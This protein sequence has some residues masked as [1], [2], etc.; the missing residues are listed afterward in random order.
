MLVAFQGFPAPPGGKKTGAVMENVFVLGYSILLLRSANN[1]GCGAAQRLPLLLSAEKKGW[2]NMFNKR[3]VIGIAILFSMIIAVFSLPAIA[4]EGYGNPQWEKIYD[5]YV[6]NSMTYHDGLY[7]GVGYDGNIGIS[8][9]GIDWEYPRSGTLRSLADITYGAA[10]FVAVG[11]RVILISDDGESWQP[12]ELGLTSTL[13]SIAY[14]GYIFIALTTDGFFMTSLDGLNWEEY[15]LED[16]ENRIQVWSIFT[17]GGNFFASD[18]SRLFISENGIDWDPIITGKESIGNGT[19]YYSNVINHKGAYMVWGRDYADNFFVVVSAD[20]KE[21][22]TKDIL[23]PEFFRQIISD[24]ERILA[25]GR[26]NIYISL[27]GFAWDEHAVN[28][29]ESTNKSICYLNGVFF[30]TI[31]GEKLFISTNGLDWT[32]IS[33]AKNTELGL[34]TA[35]GSD[36]NLVNNYNKTPEIAT[37]GRIQVK[38]GGQET[39]D[40]TTGDGAFDATMS[41]GTVSTSIDGKKWET[42]T[43]NNA[44]GLSAVTYGKG[45][46]VAVGSLGSIVTSPDGISWKK[47]AY[48]SPPGSGRP[49][50]LYDIIWDKGQYIAAGASGIIIYSTDGITWV[51]EENL[52]TGYTINQLLWDDDRYVG[53]CKEAIITAKRTRNFADIENHWAKNEIISLVEKGV[54]KG[55]SSTSFEPERAISRAEFSALLV[56]A[57]QLT[58]NGSRVGFS[59]LP[60]SNWFYQDIMILCQNEIL[61]GYEDKT[62]RPAKAISREEAMTMIARAMKLIEADIE[63]FGSTGDELLQTFADYLLIS[64]WAKESVA[65]C[66][67]ANIVKGSG[68][69]I[70][71]AKDITRAETAAIIARLLS[72]IESN[73]NNKI[74]GS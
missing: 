67:G 23:L 29:G 4:V 20:G 45:Q 39:E 70:H 26:D 56:R 1:M 3:I 74:N 13:K 47:Q 5:S 49:D 51:P 68:N 7:V 63:E 14:N 25:L 21:W 18:N 22:E 24:G 6:F 65:I 17:D 32:E 62:I 30:R 71:P 52:A 61:H 31:Y 33:G 15:Y 48:P 41:I 60:Q 35:A 42:R 37:N 34:I 11:D 53:V 16:S 27:D 64:E 43:L 55:V 2:V 72:L 50:P 73:F 59:D 44:Y 28:E 66:V 57:L 58:D 38:V 36:F 8:E 19:I 10:K 9:N 40:I 69:K 46:F 54:V 12:L